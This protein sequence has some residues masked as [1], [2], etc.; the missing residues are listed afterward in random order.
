M[1]FAHDCAGNICVDEILIESKMG[2]STTI[3][4]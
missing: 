3:A 4:L 2:P 1:D